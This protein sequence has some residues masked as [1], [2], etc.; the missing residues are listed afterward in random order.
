MMTLFPWRFLEIFSPLNES[1]IARRGFYSCLRPHSKQLEFGSILWSGTWI[2]MDPWVCS[3][4]WSMQT[5]K[6]VPWQTVKWPEGMWTYFAHLIFC[7]PKNTGKN[8]TPIFSRP[9][10]RSPWSMTGDILWLLYPTEVPMSMCRSVW[11]LTDQS[12]RVIGGLYTIR[13]TNWEWQWMIYPC[14]SHF[15][16]L[17]SFDAASARHHR[18][19][20]AGPIWTA[21]ART[22]S[23]DFES[24]QVCSCL[25][26]QNGERAA[27]MGMNQCKWCWNFF[28]YGWSVLRIF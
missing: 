27:N 2:N 10:P 9:Q 18:T 17:S 22:S 13:T 12:F 14:G 7:H 25:V 3:L 26:P 23:F 19:S 24:A 5:K 21:S 8:K 1:I 16:D 6:D 4:R 28:Q 20:L 11:D 15:D